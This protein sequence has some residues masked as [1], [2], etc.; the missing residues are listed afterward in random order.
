MQPTLRKSLNNYFL[1]L[2][3]ID[4]NPRV[5]LYAHENI[6]SLSGVDITQDDL[7]KFYEEGYTTN[8]ATK[9][10]APS[11]LNFP[12]SA[13]VTRADRHDYLYL[14]S[15]TDKYLSSEVFCSDKLHVK[16]V[17]EIS[18]DARVC[19]L[20]SL[21]NPK[22]QEYK[23]GNYNLELK[24]I[25]KPVELLACIKTIVSCIPDFAKDFCKKISKLD[26]HYFHNIEESKEV[27]YYSRISSLCLV[28][29]PTIK[30]HPKFKQY[31][32]KHKETVDV[33]YLSNLA[34]HDNTHLNSVN[35]VLA[36]KNIYVNHVP[37]TSGNPYVHD[38]LIKAS[39]NSVLNFFLQKGLAVSIYR[40]A[41]TTYTHTF[42]GSTLF[43]DNVSTSI[44]IRITSGIDHLVELLNHYFT[45]MY[46]SIYYMFCPSTIKGKILTTNTS[47]IVT[48]PNH[49]DILAYLGTRNNLKEISVY[50]DN[51]KQ[52]NNRVVDF[53]KCKKEAKKTKYTDAFK[54]T[55]HY[56]PYI[57]KENKT[58]LDDELYSYSIKNNISGNILFD[59]VVSTLDTMQKHGNNIWVKQCEINYKKFLEFKTDYDACRKDKQSRFG[60]SSNCFSIA[61][62]VLALRA[63]NSSKTFVEKLN[64]DR[65]FSLLN[66]AR[67][68]QHRTMINSPECPEYIKDMTLHGIRELIDTSTKRNEVIAAIQ[69]PQNLTGHTPEVF[70]SQYMNP[71]TY[72]EI[73]NPTSNYLKSI[74]HFNGGTLHEIGVHEALFD[75]K[76]GLVKILGENIN[77]PSKEFFS[78]VCAVINLV[79]TLLVNVRC[80]SKGNVFT[81]GYATREQAANPYFYLKSIVEELD[82][83]Y[84]EQ[85]TKCNNVRELYNLLAKS[86]KRLVGS[87]LEPFKKVYYD[88]TVDNYLSTHYDDS[89]SENK[90]IIL[91]NTFYSAVAGDY[92]RIK[93]DPSEITKFD[94]FSTRSKRGITHIPNNFIAN[95]C[96]VKFDMIL[97][98]EEKC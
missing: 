78:V 23:D 21:V 43:L 28:T 74:K 71:A 51:R 72:T 53:L 30:K 52:A 64:S 39:Y 49:S 24:Q 73:S 10:F 32:I 12:K 13:I 26:L 96:L 27:A 62:T 63:L 31:Y 98:I 93:H 8:Y 83:F 70:A 95:N 56:L 2:K 91:D 6:D 38:P 7:T 17:L 5:T 3:K 42:D 82:Q 81:Y 50:L 1:G 46:N 41:Y 16:F 84:I 66:F 68:W 15:D 60:S 11:E 87:A 36:G 54:V 34:N 45:V 89:H 76:L 48:E 29:F 92:Y 14:D 77:N 59:D 25:A 85:S 55:R 65:V 37:D 79:T 69:N 19:D 94:Y 97:E 58:F 57:V 80:F 67:A 20:L 33:F 4:S 86:K 22:A 75:D 47:S 18:D 88:N 90:S 44:P 9:S 35:F 40:D 61:Y